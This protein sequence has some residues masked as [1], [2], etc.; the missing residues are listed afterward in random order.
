MKNQALFSSKV[1]SKKLK[2]LLLQF[3]HGP[4]RVKIFMVIFFLFQMMKE[5]QAARDHVSEMRKSDNNKAEQL[6]KDITKV[7]TFS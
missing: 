4:L 1:K 5:W 7:R 2:C 6:N 3:L